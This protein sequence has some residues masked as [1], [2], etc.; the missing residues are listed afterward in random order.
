MLKSM[1]LKGFSSCTHATLNSSQFLVDRAVTELR[2]PFL[3][4]SI[5]S[6]SGRGA[7]LTVADI[8]QLLTLLRIPFPTEG[9]GKRGAVI[10][11]DLALA[12][13]KDCFAAAF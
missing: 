8:R 6:I 12:L 11:Q 2:L 9:S 3:D 7:K 4:L 13:L 1:S 10:K 5:L